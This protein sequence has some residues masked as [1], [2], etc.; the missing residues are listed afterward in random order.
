LRS[1]IRSKY[2]VK[3]EGGNDQSQKERLWHL[4]N[5]KT[6]AAVSEL[7]FVFSASA[8]TIDSETVLNV[9]IADDTLELE[10]TVNGLE[11]PIA[12]AEFVFDSVE[13]SFL[14]VE[15]TFTKN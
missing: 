7:G 5:L 6:L 3:S 4:H 8:Q 11:Q 1:L 10:S 15:A 14:E 12:D 2:S 9:F 13:A